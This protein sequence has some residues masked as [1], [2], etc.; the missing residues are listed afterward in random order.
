M[1]SV[2]SMNILATVVASEPSET[3]NLWADEELEPE[4]EPMPVPAPRRTLVVNTCPGIFVRGVAGTSLRVGGHDVNQ[5][6]RER[7]RAQEPLS[8]RASMACAA[9]PGDCKPPLGPA[10]KHPPQVKQPLSLR[11]AKAREAWKIESP[12]LTA[13]VVQQFSTEPASNTYVPPPSAA[14]SAASS[15]TPSTSPRLSPVQA[16]VDLERLPQSSAPPTSWD[17]G[18]VAKVN[19]GPGGAHANMTS[20]TPEE[21]IILIRAVSDAGPKWSAIQ[22]QVFPGRTIASIR[23]RHHRIQKGRDALALGMTKNICR[24]CGAPKRGHVCKSAPRAQSSSTFEGPRFE[25]T[26]LRWMLPPLPPPDDEYTGPYEMASMEAAPSPTS[27]ER[28]GFMASA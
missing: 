11:A 8:S 10:I 5:P 25:E 2:Q 26:A 17:S 22:K 23:N 27:E 15:A 19:R 4:P 28:F 18:C 6:S 20:W 3:R 24:K 14:S 12:P 9:L 1:E 16:G 13:P 21:D 7:H